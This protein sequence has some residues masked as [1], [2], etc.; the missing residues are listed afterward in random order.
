MQA[1]AGEAAL[2]VDEKIVHNAAQPG[3]GLV[4]FHE[5]V[6]LAVRLDEELLEQ[7]LGFGFAARQPPGETIQAIK[8]WP[9][10][11]FE[12]VAMFSD[13]RLLLAVTAAPSTR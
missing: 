7:V 6:D 9:D 13:G 5:V 8:M 12:R 3:A 2:L 1:L 4:D 11:S 10:E